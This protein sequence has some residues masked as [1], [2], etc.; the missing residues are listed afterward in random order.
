MKKHWLILLCCCGLSAASLGISVNA[1][2]V[3]Y[4]P[5]ADDLHILRGT[6]AMH[7]T[8]FSF[9]VAIMSLFVPY[10]YKKYSFKKILNSS[11]IICVIS[12]ALMAVSN[13]IVMFYILGIIRGLSASLFS[14]VPITMIINGWFVKKH[15]FATSIAFSFS[16]LSG[17]IFSPILSSII[18][19]FNWHIGYLAKALF[20]LLFCLPAM[21]YPFSISAR[22]EG[23]LPYGY[24]KKQEAS[25]QNNN[26]FKY[27]S[28]SFICFFIFSML[29]SCIT[30]ITQHLP[31]YGQSLGYSATTCS[32]LLSAGMIGNII[33]KLI[34]GNLSDLFGELKASIIMI[35]ITICGIILLLLTNK[36][37]TLIIGAVLFGSCYSLGAVALPLLTRYFFSNDNYAKVFPKISFA[38]N[39]GA[40]L[41]LS[42]VGYIYDFFNSYSYA[43]I[44]ALGLIS[45]D[46]ILL[47]VI[48]KT[49]D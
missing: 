44:I 32:I 23:L 31:G 9:A 39:V 33:S 25:K 18:N 10:L 41:S 48:K 29:I 28:I 13:N 3:F 15:G 45:I 8:L 5:V 2:G 49:K 27:L 7:M 19:S 11:I 47:V 43:F 46:I 21:L 26:S 40:A 17:S 42:L 20:I 22:D 4:T 35:M 14:S 12:T 38:S 37:T 16:G 1:S 30:G 24:T 6:Y 34:I 36:M